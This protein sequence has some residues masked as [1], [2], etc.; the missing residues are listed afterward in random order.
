[1]F[2]QSNGKINCII[3]AELA[4]GPRRRPKPCTTFTKRRL[5][6]M[7][8]LAR[9]VFFFFFSC[10]STLGV[11]PFTFPARAKEPCT[12]PPNNGTVMSNSQLVNVLTVAKQSKIL[13][14]HDK[15]NSAESTCSNAAILSWNWSNGIMSLGWPLHSWKPTA[16]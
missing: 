14:S 5:Y 6:W 4:F 13:P 10:F 11:W 8:R 1:M 2:L 3:Y 12:L 16:S 7:R 9:P 15:V